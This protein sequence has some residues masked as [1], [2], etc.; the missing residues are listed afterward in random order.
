MYWLQ[1]RFVGAEPERHRSINDLGV[2]FDDGSCIYSFSV[3]LVEALDVI[4]AF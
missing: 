1:E 2:V 4:L 3:A